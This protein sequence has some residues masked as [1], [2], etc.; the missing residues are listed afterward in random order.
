[1]AADSF[2]KT[3]AAEMPPRSLPTAVL[4][5]GEEA[6]AVTSGGATAW[7]WVGR[8]RERVRRITLGPHPTLSLAMAGS[9]STATP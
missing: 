3:I 6:I 9:G 8:V 4:V 2:G 1:M 7:V 5:P